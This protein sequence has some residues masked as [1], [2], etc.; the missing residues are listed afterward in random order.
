M[1]M[2]TDSEIEQWVLR[3]LSL[4][5]KDLLAGSLR[6]RFRWCGQPSRQRGKL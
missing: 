3:A 2:K 6:F 1:F 4:S 5:G